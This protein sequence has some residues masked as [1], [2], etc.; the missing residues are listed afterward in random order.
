MV[1]LREF[2]GSAFPAVRDDFLHALTHPEHRSA[3]RVCCV[4]AI[5]RGSA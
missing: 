5:L 3:S 2:C 4:V 1:L